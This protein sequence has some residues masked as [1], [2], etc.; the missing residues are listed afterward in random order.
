MNSRA[1]WFRKAKW[2]VFCHYLSG[3]A[4][5]KTIEHMTVK[6]WNERVNSF[7][8]QA[9]ADQLSYVGAKYFFI[10]I[11]QNSGYYCSP[12]KT[13]DSIVGIK[14]S[15]CSERDLVMDIYKVLAP[16]GIRLLTYLPSAAPMNDPE[17]VAKLGGHNQLNVEKVRLEEFQQ[18][19]EFIIQEWSLRW[20]DKVSGWWIDGCYFADV[21]YRNPAPPNFT[22][23]AAAL[24]SGNE[25][26][27]VAFNPGIKTPV[28][29]LTEYEDYTAG[30]LDIALQVS[31]PRIQITG[32]VKQALFHVL[33]Y[34]GEYWGQGEP[35]FP[36]ELAAGYTKHIND[37]GGVI[38]WDVPI[39]NNG[40]ISDPYI[41]WLLAVGDKVSIADAA[42]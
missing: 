41:E 34:M 23:F 1:D 13:Y 3:A 29:S 42:N 11:G 2:G 30:E 10:T 6:K 19:W 16:K 35:R 36:K 15:K 38:S 5:S 18:N 33:T 21:M 31:A 37:H 39:S 7:D 8:V 24:R 17:A 14:P 12:N 9:L 27:I 4:S 26:S 22:S 25:N 32:Y 40:H 28:I 20:G